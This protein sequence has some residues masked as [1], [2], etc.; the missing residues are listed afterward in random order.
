M[1]QQTFGGDWTEEK[2]KRIDMY[3][4]AYT[5]ILDKRNFR[6]AYIDAFAGTGYRTLEQEQYQNELMFPMLFEESL[7]FYRGSAQIALQVQPRFTRYIFIEK[8]IERFKELK[9]LKVDY[10]ELAEDI[11]PINSDCNS[12]LQDLCL[13]YKWKR[14]RAVLFLDPFGMQVEWNTI[15]AIA[16]TKAIDLWLLFPLGVA[17][18]RLLRRDGQISDIFQQKLNN[19]FGTTDWFDAF[20]APKQQPSLFDDDLGLEKRVTLKQIGDYFVQ[21]L[22]SVFEH[23][24]ENPLP[25]YNSKGN[26]LY[27]LCFAAHNK[28]AVKIAQHILT[29]R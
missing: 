28:T 8:D 26:P 18:N 25:L 27:L 20:Y 21:R 23:V 22:Q 1:Y 17:V 19:L 10:P 16:S 3:L 9:Q 15:E 12:Y 5:K 14:N 29:S 11:W 2:L 4:R 6:F 7:K 13:N 24:A